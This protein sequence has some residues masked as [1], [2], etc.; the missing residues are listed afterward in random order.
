MGIVQKDAL[1]TTIISS[2]GLILGY[3]NKGLFFLLIF[4]TE[5]IG[6]VNLVFSLGVLFAQFSNFGAIYS[7]WK[8]FP[9]FKNKENKHHGFLSF[10]LLIVLLGAGIVSLFFLLFRSNI[11][12]I[13]ESKSPMFL[14]YYLW[15]IPL[16]IGYLMYLVF[17][18]Y[19]RSLFKNVISV[20]AM[21]VVL[22]LVVS[23]LLLLFW[24][25]LIDFNDFVLAHSLV[26]F[27]PPLI[28]IF[29][30]KYLGELFI[31]PRKINISKRFKKIIFNY[32]AFNYMNT[33]GRVLVNALDVIMIAQ[34]IGLKATG[35][36]TTVVFLTSAIQVPYKSLIRVSSPLISE[37]WKNRNFSGMKLLYRQVS[38]VSL[39]IG[40]GL[41][42]CVWVNID[43]LFSFLKPEFS[44]GI[45][46]FFFLMMGRLLD[47]YFGL[48][49][50]IFTSSKKYKYD[51]IFTLSLIGVVYF[52][53]LY[54]IPIYGI[55]GAA[56]S[57]AVAL[58]LYNLGRLLFVYF[59]YSVHPFNWKQFLIIILGILSI[60]LVINI[61]MFD[62]NV[63]IQFIL[64][65]IITA[66]VFFGTILL[67]D[68]EVE[69][70]NYIRK[71]LRFI[72]Y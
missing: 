7:I 70:K 40:L 63:W 49:G 46:V 51:L 15:V 18:V 48:N 44:D 4:S 11:E 34:F 39:V 28:L 67:F 68:L 1:R 69:T 57:T 5:Q 42:I 66:F 30:L 50:H 29:Y 56:I 20:F 58:I 10:S 23:L 35:V 61:P 19:L 52:L 22:R 33:L 24:L 12:H 2:F 65:T 37:H 13:Y 55:I 25:E 43:F 41:F 71:A 60:I 6:V 54:L 59:A 26:F 21:D 62:L 32:S 47:M 38:S 9:F 3:L 45:W 16:G 64:K 17:E 27:I 31:D 8:F 14:D 36:Y 72:K 53:N